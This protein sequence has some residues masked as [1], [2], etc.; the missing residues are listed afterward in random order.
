MRGLLTIEKSGKIRIVETGTDVDQLLERQTDNLYFFHTHSTS[1]HT[2]N[3]YLPSINDII[4]THTRIKKFHYIII[5][6]RI[7]VLQKNGPL[8]PLDRY[9]DFL[10]RNCYQKSISEQAIKDKLED[11]NI[12]ITYR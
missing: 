10:M 2:C 6:S 4:L 5:G 9:V 7:A 1:S 3:P 8:V 12:L 11:V